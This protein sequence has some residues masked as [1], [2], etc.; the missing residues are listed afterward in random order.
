MLTRPTQTLALLAITIVLLAVSYQ[1]PQRDRI[2]IGKEWDQAVSSGFYFAEENNGNSFRWSSGLAQVDFRG[3]GKRDAQLTLAMAGFRPDGPAT[4]T[5]LLNQTI[6]LATVTLD[7]AVK[8]YT[9][10]I[11]Q[12]SI[13]PNGDVLITIEAPTFTAPPDTRTLG[14]Q[15]YSAELSA[16]HWS[17][18]LPPL[19]SWLEMTIIVVLLAAAADRLKLR[20][21]I[22]WVW[23]LLVLALLIVAN[24][25]ASPWFDVYLPWLVGFGLICWLISGWMCAATVWEWLLLLGVGV[26]AFRFGARAYDFFQTGL[27][28]GDFS[29]YFSAAQN[30]YHGQPIYDFKAA[31]EMPN[32]PV[33]KYPPLFAM[34]LA[35]FG[36]WPAWNVAA[37]W[38]LL[39][40][41]LYTLIFVML[42]GEIGRLYPQ[43]RRVLT[44]LTALLFLNFQPTWESLIRGQLDIV[45]LICAM[46]GLVLYLRRQQ[47]WVGGVA[48]S[49]ATMLKLY[50]GFL[51]V[52]LLWRRR[53]QALLGFMAGFGLLAVLSGLVVGWDVLW[54]YVSE[55]LTVQTAAVPYPENQSW[56]GFLSRF[57]IPV[58]DTVWYTTIPFSTPW[59]LLLYV[60]VLFTL[61]VTVLWIWRYPSGEG[62]HRRFILGYGAALLV[63][64]LLWPTSWMHYQTLLLPTFALLLS[65]Q[66]DAQRRSWW[67]FVLLAVSFALIAF[68]NEYTVLVERWNV[69]GW[70]RL[71]QSYKF[72]G[73]IVLWLL[74]AVANLPVKEQTTPP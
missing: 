20:T 49:F 27:P 38:Y 16:S 32:G 71:A 33:Y 4:A 60:C 65:D 52:Y 39:N 50:P 69:D 46:L 61:L 43:R 73:M 63:M 5:I 70:P 18:T 48:L 26:S 45:I 74:C 37:A 47:E 10:P 67:K 23:S 42:T 58:A 51:A 36:G 72:F 41:L 30:L 53:W 59:R 9:F 56:D 21:N 11:S 1:A 34:L 17:L 31:S 6:P 25:L 44:L 64:V 24:R 28:Q 15:I 62:D 3:F 54:R 13:A 19:V 7:P 22:W 29:I 35:P 57:V 14:V 68:G 12:Q 55:V 66:F 40:L 2:L 8:P